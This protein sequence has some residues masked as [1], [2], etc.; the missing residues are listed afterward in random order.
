MI[1]LSERLKMIADNIEP[2]SGVADIGTDHGYLPIYLCQ[3]KKYGKVIATDVNT[4]PLQKAKAN[5]ILTVP[6]MKPDL[7]LGDGLDPL[8]PG[9]VETV[10][11]AGM[12]GYLI[13]DI[14][15]WDLGKTLT[16]KRFILQ[17]RNNSGKLRRDLYKL[18]FRILRED[19]AFEQNRFCEIITCEPPKEV[20]RA[21]E[22]A[23]SG[24][25][26][27]EV[28]FDYPDLLIKVSLRNVRS[29]LESLLRTENEIMANIGEGTGGAGTED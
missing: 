15:T 26:P 21:C 10:V 29:Y 8:K 6:D 17:P 18:G 1:K 27:S 19:I 12:G 28:S 14:L 20:Q 25:R 2:G 5:F 7:R 4:G 23:E 11:I 22:P 3:T 24:F 16:Y 9:E 13:S